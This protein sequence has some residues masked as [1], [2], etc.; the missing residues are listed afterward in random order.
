MEM[1]VVWS[2][3]AIDDIQ[4]IHDYYSSTVNLKVANKIIDKIVEKSIFLE[5]NPRIGQIEELLEHKQ[6]EIRYLVEG[7]YKIVYWIDDN[8]VIIATVFDCRQDP[9]KLKNKNF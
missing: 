8:N 3:S 9:I 4:E 1:I 6:I 2:D 5:N 7:N